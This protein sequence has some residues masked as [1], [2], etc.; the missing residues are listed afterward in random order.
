MG[1]ENRREADMG[2]IRFCRKGKREILGPPPQKKLL[3]REKICGWYC[4]SVQHVRTVGRDSLASDKRSN[5]DCLMRD[6]NG[7]GL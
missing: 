5:R 4:T 2:Y 6:Y 1:Y 3:K 7:T